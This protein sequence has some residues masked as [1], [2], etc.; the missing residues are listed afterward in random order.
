MNHLEELLFQYYDWQGYVVKRNILVGPRKKGGYEC[1]LDIVAFCHQGTHLIHVEPSLDT[2][3]WEEREKRFKKKFDAGKK[4]IFKEV[5]PWLHPSTE[6][7]QIAILPSKS[8]DREQIGGGK[9]ETIDQ[10]VKKIK[11]EIFNKGKMARNAIS[12]QY[13]L[14]RTIQMTICGYH[15]L[16]NN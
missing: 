2:D 9:I 3:S 14:L 13:G 5:F 1:E 6:I 15:K 11:D 7:E 16:H 10:V 8:K 4:Y 12:E